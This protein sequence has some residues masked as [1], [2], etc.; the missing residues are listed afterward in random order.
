MN[1]FRRKG[2]NDSSGSQPSLAL[3]SSNM[4]AQVAGSS[5][6]DAA[7]VASKLV[8]RGKQGHTDM[9]GDVA[10][11][12]G[13]K[14]ANAAMILGIVQAICEVLDKVPYV[15]VVTGLA[16]TA[17]KIIEAVNACKEEWDKVKGDLNKVRDIVFEFRYG[18][19]DS[20]PLPSD[21]KAAFRELESC[22]RE[23]LEAVIRYQDPCRVS[24][25]LIWQSRSFR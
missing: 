21:V 24:D 19:D 20:A 6:N 1:I 12:P 7:S 5:S 4:P 22:L 25:A 9:T 17:I 3:P 15:K 13:N 18:W 14:T 10:T 11:R 2:Q 23:V 8:H 16:N